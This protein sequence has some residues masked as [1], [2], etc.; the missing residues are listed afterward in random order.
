MIF[1]ISSAFGQASEAA[2]E[3]MAVQIANAG[4]S[5]AW[6]WARATAAP[7]SDVARRPG[8]DTVCDRDDKIANEAIGR[9]GFVE[10]Q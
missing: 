6:D 5:E 1:I 2:L 4:Q 7:R 10:M 9:K 8:N 3:T